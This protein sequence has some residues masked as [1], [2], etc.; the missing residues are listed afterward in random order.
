MFPRFGNVA[1]SWVIIQ[2]LLCLSAKR[3][4]NEV[5]SPKS[6]KV[7]YVNKS[8]QRCL[9]VC[10]V[11][12]SEI[13]RG[14][15]SPAVREYWEVKEIQ[16][17]QEVSKRSLTL[18]MRVSALQFSTSVEVRVLIVR[19]SVTDFLGEPRI[20]FL[21]FF[22][23]MFLTIRVRNVH[24][25]FFRENPWSFNNH[26]TVPKTAIFKGFSTLSAFWRK[27][28]PLMVTFYALIW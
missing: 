2:K 16:E 25:R 24:G 21:S 7:S 15:F 6:Q 19:R 13:S 12:Q 23:W 3:A 26:D 1:R 14:L 5:K 22:A 8:S 11:H 10:L 27:S 4:E 17:V 9:K 28:K 20:G 18:R